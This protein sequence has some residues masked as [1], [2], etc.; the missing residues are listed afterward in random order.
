MENQTKQGSGKFTFFLG[1]FAGLALISVVGFLL[2]IGMMFGNRES[3]DLA[4]SAGD[5]QV[6]ADTTQT[7]D[8]VAEP[9]RAISAD[10]HYK[11]NLNAPIQ[12]IVYDDFECPY[13]LKHEDTLKQVLET[14]GDKVVM[15]YRHYPLSFHENAQK[16]AEASECAAEQG[17][18]WEM[19]DK[20]FEAQGTKTLGVDQFKKIAK[21]LGL[22][23]AKFNE[24]L[25]SGKYLDKI[26]ADLADGVKF[27]VQGTPGNFVNGIAV[28][29]AYPFEQFQ[30]IIDSLLA[31]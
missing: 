20:I 19:H 30:Q 4:A 15:A 3:V 17:K 29:G 13:C 24:C 26:N 23:T 5:T 2:L 8:T 27:G 7:Q 6:V 25:D 16:A 22:N 14:Y 9:V 28:S 21:T 1:F 10:D 31:Q 11:G 18:F 12:L